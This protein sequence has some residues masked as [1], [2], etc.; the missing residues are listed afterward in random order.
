MWVAYYRDDKGNE[1]EVKSKDLVALNA[2]LI[3]LIETKNIDVDSIY[4][5]EI[6][7]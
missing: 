7:E 5:E 2:E 3:N 1:F 6:E 4:I